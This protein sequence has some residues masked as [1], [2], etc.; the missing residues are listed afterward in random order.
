MNPTEWK[1]RKLQLWNR[2]CPCLG[3]CLGVGERVLFNSSC[4][5]AHSVI[6]AAVKVAEMLY[7]AT[8][9]YQVDPVHGGAGEPWRSR[10][11]R[12]T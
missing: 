10:I 8:A 3:S 11:T 9:T 6:S 1:Q 5:D 4:S 2:V 7:N 12:T